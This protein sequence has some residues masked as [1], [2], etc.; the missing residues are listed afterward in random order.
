M[1]VQEFVSVVGVKS[2]L[3]GE[4][5]TFISGRDLTWKKIC[6]WGLSVSYVML[7]FYAASVQDYTKL[8][9]HIVQTEKGKKH[10]KCGIS[11][12]H[13]RGAWCAKLF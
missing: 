4:N 7:L 6:S 9:I 12:A 5:K 10:C 11:I 8:A 3:R 2:H 13:M 1:T